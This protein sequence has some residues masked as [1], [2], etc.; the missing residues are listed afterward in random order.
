MLKKEPLGMI[1]VFMKRHV[2]NYLG[3]IFLQHMYPWRKLI[4]TRFLLICYQKL[5]LYETFLRRIIYA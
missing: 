1:E 4:E 2:E 5:E 3:A